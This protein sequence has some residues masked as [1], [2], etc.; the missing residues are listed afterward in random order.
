M[1]SRI[2]GLLGQITTGLTNVSDLVAKQVNTNNQKPVMTP[3]EL[4]DLISQLT[5]VCNTIGGVITQ[6]QA[7]VTVSVSPTGTIP[8]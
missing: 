8:G 4:E 2:L 3:A 6:L 7:P 5:G 1:D